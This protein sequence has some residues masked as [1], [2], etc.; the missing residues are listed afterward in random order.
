MRANSELRSLMRKRGLTFWMV[1]GWMFMSERHF[2][3]LMSE[4]LDKEAKW[5]VLMAMDC[6]EHEFFGSK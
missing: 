4:E 6:A 3:E 2:R 1:A 5:A